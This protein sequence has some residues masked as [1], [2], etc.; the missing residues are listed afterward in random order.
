MNEENPREVL[1]PYKEV[2]KVIVNMALGD[3]DEEPPEIPNPESQKNRREGAY[4]DSIRQAV[5]NAIIEFR[6]ENGHLPTHVHL[7]TDPVRNSSPHIF[8]GLKVFGTQT[9]NP[10]NL[11]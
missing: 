11:R 8:E 3:G 9:S 1:T 7:R 5:T 10:M 2:G 4:L 6:K